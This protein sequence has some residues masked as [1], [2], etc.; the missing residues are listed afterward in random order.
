M[1]SS[2]KCALVLTVG[3]GDRNDPEGTLFTPLLKSIADGVWDRITL[4]PSVTT[5]DN[6]TKLEQRLSN[7]QIRI[8]PLPRDGDENDVDACFAHFNRVIQELRTEGFA[9]ADICVD[10]TRGTK[11]MSA[12]VVLA[13][14][15]HHLRQLRYLEGERDPARQNMVIPQTERVKTVNPQ[16]ATASLRL[17]QARAF[18]MDGDFAAALG[19]LPEI[20]DASDSGWPDDLLPA[21]IAVRAWAELYSAWDRLDYAAAEIKIAELPQAPP[22]TWE[23]FAP[24]PAALDWV[25]A[26]ARDSPKKSGKPLPPGEGAEMANHARR[27]MTDVL[28][29]GR[30]RIRQRQYEDANL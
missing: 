23:N 8:S 22:P 13:A 9:E 12:A 15:R 30:R 6:A 11:A 19:V 3:W 14:I 4:L 5:L 18:L 7:V 28:A 1:A 24:T 26:L 20:A 27:I 17:D 21:L 2:S 29:N 10:F 25:R 16:A